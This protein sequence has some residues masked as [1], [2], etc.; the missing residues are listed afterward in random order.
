VDQVS[1]RKRLARCFIDVF[2][3]GLKENVYEANEGNVASW[4]SMETWRLAMSVEEEFGI[5]VS[6]DRLSSLNSFVAFESYII[7]RVDA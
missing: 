3:S 4:D 7:D 1:V 2:G 5:R 6:L